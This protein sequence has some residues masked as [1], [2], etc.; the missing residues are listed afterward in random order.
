MSSVEVEPDIF[1][2][3]KRYR[4]ATEESAAY[5]SHMDDALLETICPGCGH[6]VAAFIVDGPDPVFADVV[7]PRD[8]CEHEW[9]ER[10][11]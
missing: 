7:C 9:S 11:A 10:V 1:G 5:A 4:E 2:D 8:V 3:A 6:L